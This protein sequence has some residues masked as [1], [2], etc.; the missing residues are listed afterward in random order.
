MGC[1]G[2]TNNAKKA[3]GL[4]R[5]RTAIKKNFRQGRPETGPKQA[6]VAVANNNNEIEKE[7]HNFEV[8]ES[9]ANP[10]VEKDPAKVAAGPARKPT[11]QIVVSDNYNK[12]DISTIVSEFSGKK[13]MDICGET[14]KFV[15]LFE[16]DNYITDDWSPLLFAIHNQNLKAVRYFIEHQRYHRRLSMKKR[17]LG[18]DETQY[19][20]EAFPLIIAISNQDEAMLD[21]LWS[22][23]ELWDNEHLKVV[24]QVIFT[25]NLWTMGMKILLG[26]EATQ[27]IYNSLCYTEKKQFILELFYRYLYYAPED[28]K[29]YIK[30]VSMESPY[31]LVALQYIMTEKEDSI[32]DLIDESLKYITVEEYA[33]MKYEADKEFLKFWDEIFNQF[34]ERDGNFIDIAQKVKK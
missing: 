11:T 3:N 15:H 1:N 12:D 22:M 6:S 2:S 10:L 9:N 13:D 28:M 27:D 7:T 20:A 23:N 33:K 24:L 17:V 26:S 4:K 21:Y 25:R 19:S 5:K 32:I 16:K 29:E 14:P 31:S 34:I 18:T 30:G 8:Q